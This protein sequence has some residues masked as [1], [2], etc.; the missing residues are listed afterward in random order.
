MNLMIF[1]DNDNDFPYDKLEL[2]VNQTKEQKEY[3]E[4]QIAQDITNKYNDLI[5]KKN[6]T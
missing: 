1:K 2:T 3:M 5:T 4:D 6:D